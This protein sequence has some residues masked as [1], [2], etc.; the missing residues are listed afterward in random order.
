[1]TAASTFVLT[2]SPLVGPTTW[3]GAGCALVAR[4][5]V[6]VVPSMLGFADDRVPHWT[7]FVDRLVAACRQVSGPLTLV[8]H[9]GAGLMLPAAVDLL[10]GRVTGVVF[11][12][13]ALPPVATSI[14]VAPSWLRDHV[15]PLAVDGV[16]PPWSAWWGADV[17]SDL[18]PDAGLRA[19][20]EAEMPYLPLAYLEQVV[21]VPN[22][23]SDGISCAYL[24]CSDGYSAEAMQATERGWRVARLPGTHLHAATHPVEFAL[25]LSE[26]ATG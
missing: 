1:M 9:S 11:A 18:V 16:L 25:A 10:G 17:M 15:R 4:G 26:I 12:D 23:W 13:A 5:R 21:T 8:A 6:A 7:G 3:T 19:A 24:W 14:E 20:I 2:H 22:G